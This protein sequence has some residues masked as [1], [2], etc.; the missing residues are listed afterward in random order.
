MMVPRCCWRLGWAA[1]DAPISAQIAKMHQYMVSS[2]P[3]FV[4]RAA[5]QALK[6][7]VAP[8]RD[9]YR[10]RCNYVLARLKENGLDVV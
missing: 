8:A 5:I 7:D 2:V 9:V 1:A 6:E 4:Q 3:S 10:V